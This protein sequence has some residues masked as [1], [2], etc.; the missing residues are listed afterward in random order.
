MNLK[1][2]FSIAAITVTLLSGCSTTPPAQNA[3][4][5]RKGV[6]QGAYG[7]EFETFVVKRPYKEVASVIKAKTRDCLNAEVA[8]QSCRRSGFMSTSC[9]NYSDKYT[10]TVIDGLQKT[11]LHVQF[12]RSGE[13][14]GEFNLGGKP[15]ASGMY[16]VVADVT[17]VENG[18]AAK[19]EI[20]GNQV[21]RSIPKAIRHWANGTNLGCP[22]L[23]MEVT[24]PGAA[25]SSSETN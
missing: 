16:M 15:P 25:R 19:V 20:Y 8:N 5:Y 9:N 6:S 7:S 21:Q 12:K 23:K 17:S 18:K 22:D 13:G 4:E 3:D 24:I 1:N 2:A 14:V 11:E 10:P